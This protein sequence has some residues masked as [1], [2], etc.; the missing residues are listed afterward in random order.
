M[1]WVN[2]GEL[3]R[4]RRA[5]PR[6]RAKFSK[7]I[8]HF[9]GCRRS[10]VRLGFVLKTIL[11]YRLLFYMMLP[12]EIWN[13]AE[14]VGE[15]IPPPPGQTRTQLLPLHSLSWENFERLC[16]RLAARSGDVADCRRYGISGQ[17]QQG[18]DLY[19]RHSSRPSYSVWQCKRHE[20]F[21]VCT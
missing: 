11:R 19:I 21:W 7:R 15:N 1:P 20:T 17:N 12:A 13:V 18:I 4:I 16:C 2:C 10:V 8:A 5:P 9:R 6:A 14:N 3:A